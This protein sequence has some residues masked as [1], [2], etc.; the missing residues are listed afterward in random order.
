MK[1]SEYLFRGFSY[2]NGNVA[3]FL[4]EG[5]EE[6]SPTVRLQIGT[7]KARPERAYHS[8][9]EQSPGGKLLWV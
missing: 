4:E 8:N 6:R 7:E 2:S 5:E 9:K 1:I 3:R